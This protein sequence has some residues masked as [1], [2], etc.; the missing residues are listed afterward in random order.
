[1]VGLYIVGIFLYWICGCLYLKHQSKVRPQDDESPSDVLLLFGGIV[2]P[3]SIL[4][5][6]G[7]Y[8]IEGILGRGNGHR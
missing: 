2:F 6:I 4:I 1:M 5:I 8:I 3:L 7:T